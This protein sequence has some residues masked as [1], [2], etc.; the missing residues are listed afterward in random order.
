MRNGSVFASIEDSVSHPDT[1]EVTHENDHHHYAARPQHGTAAK[2]IAA[3]LGGKAVSIG[4]AEPATSR[5]TSCAG[6]S[7]LGRRRGSGRLAA[8]FEKLQAAPL[9][10]RKVAL[11]GLGDQLTFG[12]SFVDAMAFSLEE[13][14]T[15][16]AKII[17]AWPSRGTVTKP[18]AVRTARLS[19]WPWTTTTNR[20]DK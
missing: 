3:E 5:P 16:G 11:F 2:Q 18:R 9:T 7:D 8:N 17:G 13:A 19:A 6:F 10:D 12:T 14:E 1:K 15:R 20:P 4:Q